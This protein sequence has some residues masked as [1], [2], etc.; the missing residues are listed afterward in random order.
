MIKASE[1][2]ISALSTVRLGIIEFEALVE[3]GGSDLWNYIDKE[4]KALSKRLQLDSI[5][6]NNIIAE[7]RKAYKLCGKDPSRYRPS[8][9]SLM[10]RIVKGNNLYNVNNVVDV[11][12]LISVLSGYSIGGYD[13]QKLSGQIILDIGTEQDEY[14]GIG[15]GKLNIEGMPV[16]RD[17]VSIFGS[18]TS[19]SERTMITETAKNILFV[20]YD[21]GLHEILD[22]TLNQAVELLKKYAKGGNFTISSVL[23]T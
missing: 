17:D 7:T 4:T 11:L 9:D 23:I 10:R 5:T 19:D 16:I 1:K 8:A 22:N 6:Q 21:F 14:F 15:R 2:I 13:K 20:F 12:N 3:P 18:P